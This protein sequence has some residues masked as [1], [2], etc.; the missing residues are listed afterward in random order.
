[1]EKR[2]VEKAIEK[3][4]VDTAESLGVKGKC[5]YNSYLHCEGV[6]E[7]DDGTYFGEACLKYDVHVPSDVAEKFCEK[8]NE[9]LRTGGAPFDAIVDGESED[10]KILVAFLLW[11]DPEGYEEKEGG[12]ATKKIEKEKTLCERVGVAYDDKKEKALM[13]YKG[14]YDSVESPNYELNVA[15]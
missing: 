3:V 1:M 7:E 10:E 8:A 15:F 11:Y 2:A 14:R 6:Y 13:G 12:Y 9:T 5:Y 4:L